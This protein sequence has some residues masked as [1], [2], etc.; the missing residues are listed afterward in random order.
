MRERLASFV[1]SKGFEPAVFSGRL[2]SVPSLVSGARERGTGY[3]VCD[4]RLFEGHYARFTGAEAVAGF[5]DT[6]AIAPVLVTGYEKEDAETSIRMHRRKVPALLHSTE[7]TPDRLVDTL[8]AAERE[9]VQGILP[10]EREPC[11][12]VMSITE[13]IP[14]G[15]EKIV[16]VV[17]AQWDPQHEVGFPLSMVPASFHHAVRPGAFLYAD[18]NV[19]APRQEDLFFENFSLPN[20]ADVQAAESYF[21]NP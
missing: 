1:R 7:L 19:D 6:K 8:M 21:D 13:L 12:A 5:Y 4:H 3:A 11:P 18:V 10:A 2:S 14:A 16:R 20:P 17:I 15:R 9:A